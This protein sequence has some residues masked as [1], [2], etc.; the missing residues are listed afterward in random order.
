MT[1]EILEL[2]ARAEAVNDTQMCA[3]AVVE[4]RNEFRRL[5]C[6]VSVNWRAVADKQREVEIAYLNILDAIKMQAKETLK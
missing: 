3:R 6:D 4:L 2:E 5:G 1:C